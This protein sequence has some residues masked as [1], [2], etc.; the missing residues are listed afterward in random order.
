M[1]CCQ[2]QNNACA[3]LQPERCAA[4]WFPAILRCMNASRQKIIELLREVHL[5][6]YKEI[7]RLNLRIAELENH[8][9]APRSNAN[10]N[11]RWLSGHLPIHLRRKVVSPAANGPHFARRTSR[12]GHAKADTFTAEFSCKLCDEPFEAKCRQDWRCF[13]GTQN[14]CFRSTQNHCAEEDKGGT[15]ASQTQPI[16]KWRDS[17][18]WL[19]TLGNTIGKRASRSGAMA[20]RAPLIHKA[21]AVWKGPLLR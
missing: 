6:A 11:D 13:R 2:S 10:Q 1:R 14:H 20:S 15:K 18:R 5:I 7:E 17:H 16:P 19:D 21:N 8:V 12:S 3:A 4:R 9:C